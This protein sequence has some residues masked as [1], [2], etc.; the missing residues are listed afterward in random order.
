MGRQALSTRETRE[1]E[2]AGKVPALPVV[3]FFARARKTTRGARALPEQGG[4]PGCR[5]ASFMGG[6][7]AGWP[8]VCG[9]PETNSCFIWSPGNQF[10]NVRSTA[11]FSTQSRSIRETR[12]AVMG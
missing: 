9:L 4:A 1:K 12:L 6:I 8:K 5:L 10:F 3:G 2:H 11:V 7:M